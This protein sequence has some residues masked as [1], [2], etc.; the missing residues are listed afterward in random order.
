MKK[1]CLAFAIMMFSFCIPVA[2]ADEG[3]WLPILLQKMNI[4]DM[5]RLGLKLSAEDIYAINHSSLKDA[6]VQFG[7]GCTGEMVSP[8]GLLFTNHHCGY[9]QIQAHSSVEHDYLTDGFW[10]K[11]KAEELPNPGLTVKFLVKMEKVTDKVVKHLA[12]NMTETQRRDTIFSVTRQIAKEAEE[13][14]KYETNVKSY[15]EG[16]EYYLLVY[17]VYEDVRLVG[18]PPNSI[19]KFGADADNWMWPRHTCDFSIFRVYM[20]PDGKPAP[21]HKD[22]VPYQPKHYLPISLAGVQNGDFSMI[23]GYPGTT[24]RFL[25][26]FGVQQIM[27]IQAPAIVEIRGAKLDVFSKYM[28][29]DPK[30]RIQYSSK[31]AGVANYWKYFIGQGKQLKQNNVVAKKQQIEKEFAAWA[32][33]KPEYSNVLKDLEEGY[34]LLAENGKLLWYTMEAIL[35]GPEVF[36]MALNFNS[37]EKALECK[38][39]TQIQNAVKSIRS[40]LPDFF[41]NYSP[42][43]NKELTFRMLQMFNENIVDSLQPANFIAWVDKNKKD[44]LSLSDQIFSKTMMGDSAKIEAFLANPNLKSLKKDLA[45][46]WAICFRD[47]YN[48]RHNQLANEKIAVAKRLFVKG[49]REMNKDKNYAPD[50]NF[51]MRIS[52]GQVKDYA[53]AD[54]VYYDFKTTLKGVMQKE[55][56][57]N[58]DFIVPSKLKELYKIKDFGR[59]GDSTLTT[60]FLTTNDITGGNSGSPVI[61][62]KG[63]LIGLAFDGNWEAMSGDIFYEPSLQRTIVVD[64]RYV[65]FIIDKYAGATNLIEE[66]VFGKSDIAPVSLPVNRSNSM[67]SPA[68]G[69]KK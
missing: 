50:A 32:A 68:T 9:G 16:N 15:Y 23:L 59:Y 51:S 6:I 64:I 24:Q 20:S 44:Y 55:D 12:P 66:L 21:Y 2:K 1:I 33:D 10:A 14:G 35:R 52:Y 39:E 22:N 40:I 28:D 31:Y 43:L 47:N 30:V 49:I 8:D 3:M 4:E 53:P 18:T 61:N 45:Y 26:S 67:T 29:A 38:D 65:L 62:A 25:T 63:E 58:P 60:C 48:Q 56:P 46:Q 19:G 69:L 34:T 36:S 37:L 41:K 17:E 5:H 57:K 13:N 27:D 7:G 42:A 54:A 11:T